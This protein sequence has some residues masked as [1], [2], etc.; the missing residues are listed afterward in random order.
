[1]IFYTIVCD[2]CN[3]AKL[4]KVKSKKQI[5]FLKKRGSV[6]FSTSNCGECEK[7]IQKE[8]LLSNFYSITDT[9]SNPHKNLEVRLPYKD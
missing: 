7:W 5:D 2:T 3:H 8:K 6:T 4:H 1:M 9:L